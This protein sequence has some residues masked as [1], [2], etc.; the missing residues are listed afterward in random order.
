MSN[1]AELRPLNHS[2]LI[3]SYSITGY[4]VPNK[5]SFVLAS[6]LEKFDVQHSFRIV[7]HWTNT[8]SS[9]NLIACGLPYITS[10]YSYVLQLDLWPK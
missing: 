8:L 1:Y 7:L 5:N 9:A 4:L 10:M 6:I 3:P 2:R